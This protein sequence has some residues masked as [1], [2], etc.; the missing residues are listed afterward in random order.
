MPT[1]PAWGASPHVKSHPISQR[2][3]ED[4][5][6][7]ASQWQLDRCNSCLQHVEFVSARL[8]MVATRTSLF[9]NFVILRPRFCIIRP[10]LA[11]IYDKHPP[12]RQVCYISPGS[13]CQEPGS[14]Y[15]LRQAPAASLNFTAFRQWSWVMKRVLA[16]V[17]DKHPLPRL[18]LICVAKLFASRKSGSWVLALFWFYKNKF[19]S[20]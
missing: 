19:L 6:G 11:I 5:V 15:Y 9:L 1:V 8:P 2:S 3:A 20:F 17:Y 16:I 12:L 4:E 10:V 7:G 14:C 13:L 18:T